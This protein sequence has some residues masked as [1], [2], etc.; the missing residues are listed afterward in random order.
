MIAATIFSALGQI[1]FK[2]SGSDEGGAAITWW[3]AGVVAYGP[4][5]PLALRAYRLSSLT[6]M[7][8]LAG[9]MYVWTTIAAV[10]WFGE[11]LSL[12]VFV[13]TACVIAGAILVATSEV[14]ER[15]PVSEGRS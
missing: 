10:T 14:S 6:K 2:L 3:C 11:H 13:G 15:R 7:F 12:K 1:A 5:L 8:P 9:L 4:S